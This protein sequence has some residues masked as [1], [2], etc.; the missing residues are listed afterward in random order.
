[1]LPEALYLLVSGKEVLVDSSGERVALW[2]H[3]AA[4]LQGFGLTL[5]DDRFVTQPLGR[6]LTSRCAPFGQ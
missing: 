5:V 3:T 1:M 2:L 6:R 4:Q